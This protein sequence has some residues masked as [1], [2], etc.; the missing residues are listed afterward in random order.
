MN[1]LLGIHIHHLENQKHDSAFLAGPTPSVPDYVP[2]PVYEWD[3]DI[4]KFAREVEAAGRRAESWRSG[5][6]PD[7][8]GILSSWF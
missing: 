1:G 6:N 5:G 3:K 7:P 2:F 4:A 8:E